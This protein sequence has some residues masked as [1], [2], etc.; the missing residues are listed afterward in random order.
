[1]KQAN[2]KQKRN[3]WHLLFLLLELT[4]A[5]VALFSLFKVGSILLAYRQSA[6]NY[7]SIR[8]E[9]T[10]SIRSEV[11]Q[12]AD[13]SGEESAGEPHTIDFSLLQQRYPDAVGWIRCAGT[14]IDYPIMQAADNDYYLRRLPD[15]RW[16]I[17]GSVFL[18]Y[19]S[20]SD[21]LGALSLVY[22]HHM[23]DDSMFTLIENYSDPRWFDQHPTL[24]LETPQ[25]VFTLCPVAGFYIPAEQWVDSGYDLAEN[26]AAMA[27]YAAAHST[28]SAATRWDGAEPLIA[29]ITCAGYS[30]AD[31]YIL[32]CVPR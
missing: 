32:L 18:D 3:L 30:D 22:G 29:L 24:T 23:N 5:G 10:D 9:V 12:P 1:M 2:D 8:S 11:T 14:V 25:Q 19:R 26:R 6:K 15:G 13:S 21:F 7:D 16:N 27:D 28:F 20:E 4:L 31:R 17:G